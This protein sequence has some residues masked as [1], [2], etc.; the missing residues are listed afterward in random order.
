MKRIA[1]ITALIIAALFVAGFDK[2][3]PETVTVNY[4]VDGSETVWDIA[5]KLKEQYNDD[6]D[7]REIAYCI[8]EDNGGADVYSGKRLKITMERPSAK[9]WPK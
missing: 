6:R 7:I 3:E 9:D 2:T 5:G 1:I 4:T 8:A